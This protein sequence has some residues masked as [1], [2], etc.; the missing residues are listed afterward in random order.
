[1][2]IL[3]QTSKTCQIMIF[4]ILGNLLWAYGDSF[5]KS[6]KSILC[7]ML[8]NYTKLFWVSFGFPLHRPNM[9]LFYLINVDATLFFDAH[10]WI[11]EEKI[12]FL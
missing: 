1:V 8:D 2:C 12:V 5:K 6:T 11:L 3:I 4:V 10:N 7:T 9:H